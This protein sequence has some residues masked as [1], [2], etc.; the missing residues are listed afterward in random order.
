MTNLSL[1]KAITTWILDMFERR[2]FVSDELIQ[3]NA[4]RIQTLL[5]QELPA[6]KQIHLKF[7]NGWL[8]KLKVCNHFKCYR[9]H[10]ESGNADQTVVN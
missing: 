4:R 1:D 7:S 9:Y 10:G 8:E 2:V 6:E 5:N 3:V